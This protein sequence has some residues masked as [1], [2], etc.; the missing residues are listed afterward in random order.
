MAAERLGIRIKFSKLWHPAEHQAE[1]MALTGQVQKL[2]YGRH[3]S[4]L[5][6]DIGGQSRRQRSSPIRENCSS[7][8]SAFS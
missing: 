3:A 6:A 8:G 1:Q 5:A 7:R 4:T 2:L